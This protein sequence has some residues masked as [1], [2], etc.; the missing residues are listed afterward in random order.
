MYIQL[1][2]I[3]C[4][5]KSAEYETAQALLNEQYLLK[6]ELE[7]QRQALQSKIETLE[8]ELKSFQEQNDVYATLSTNQ[9]ARQ[10]ELIRENVMLQKNVARTCE[11]L[12]MLKES[13]SCMLAEKEEETEGLNTNLQSK[14]ESLKML[15]EK[16]SVLD[17][18]NASV[19]VNVDSFNIELKEKD[20]EIANVTSNLRS[21]EDAVK[22]LL[23][24]VDNLQQN[25]NR[26]L[27][28]ENELN[29]SLFE[30]GEEI[31]VINTNL[32]SKEETVKT[33]LDQ[34][35]NFQTEIT[36]R[37][38]TEELLNTTISEKED[39]L[40]TVK[41]TIDGQDQIIE[42]L[43]EEMNSTELSYQSDLRES[44]E[45]Y[46]DLLTQ[47]NV[48]SEAESTL[49]DLLQSKEDELNAS[50]MHYNDALN[51]K[52]EEIS[53]LKENLQSKEEAVKVLYGKMM[54]SAEEVRFMQE[55]D[56]EYKK[57]AEALHDQKQK[58]ISL[59]TEL[60]SSK[61]SVTA[62]FAA[63][64]E[65]RNDLA[66]ISHKNTLLE[67][68]VIKKDEE[69]GQLQ[70]NLDCLL[71]TH[72]GEVD[73]LKENL[74]ILQRKYDAVSDAESSLQS[75]LNTKEKEFSESI[76]EKDAI[77]SE[78]NEEISNLK[79]HLH[80]KDEAVKVLYEKMQETSEGKE[81]FNV[82]IQQKD[83]EY[84]RLSEILNKQQEKVEL[85]ESELQ[86]SNLQLDV[87]AEIQ[88][89]LDDVVIKKTNLEKSLNQKDEEV[90]LFKENFNNSLIERDQEIMN[91]LE[92]V[93][94]KDEAVKA[95]Y[96]E[97]QILKQKENELDLS[98]TEGDE[99]DVMLTTKD[100]QISSLLED[101]ARLKEE[102]RNI[103]D[104]KTSLSEMLTGKEKELTVC[105]DEFNAIL[106]EKE[107]E[108]SEVTSNLNSKEDTIN[109]M[110]EQ[111][112]TEGEKLEES[113]LLKE[114]IQ[115]QLLIQNSELE[116]LKNT[117]ES[118]QQEN[119][120]LKVK[121]NASQISLATAESQLNEVVSS[122]QEQLDAKTR[123]HIEFKAKATKK[124]RDLN[125]EAKLARSELTK[126]KE[127][128]VL[129]QNKIAELN[130]LYDANLKEVEVMQT[131]STD[132]M[133][134]QESIKQQNDSFTS[135]IDELNTALS[136]SESVQSGLR[137]KL[138]DWST[139]MTNLQE[140]LAERETYINDLHQESEKLTVKMKDKT[141][142]M[143]AVKNMLQD[144][145]GTMQ[146]LQERTLSAEKSLEV[147]QNEL[148]DKT[149]KVA[150]LDDWLKQKDDEYND[151]IAGKQS[152]INKMMEEAT[153]L[154]DLLLE[155]AAQKDE[156]MAE[157]EEKKLEISSLRTLSDNNETIM[158]QLNAYQEKESE[159]SDKIAKLNAQLSECSAQS[160][161]KEEF[162][163]RM[164]SKSEELRQVI[165][166]LGRKDEKL[167]E[168]QESHDELVGL[169]DVLKHKIVSNDNEIN[170]LQNERSK[171]SE[172][173]ENMKVKVARILK[174]SQAMKKVITEK[175]NENEILKNTS[176]KL[177]SKA[178][179]ANANFENIKLELERVNIDNEAIH[180]NCS[181][182]EDRIIELENSC[183]DKDTHID[184]LQSSMY[185]AS[186]LPLIKPVEESLIMAAD[187]SMAASAPS[188]TSA[189]SV[190]QELEWDP[191]VPTK[192][193]HERHCSVDIPLVSPEPLNEQLVNESLFVSS[194]E[195][196][197]F[198]PTSDIGEFV[199][200]GIIENTQQ[201]LEYTTPEDDMKDQKLAILEKDEEIKNLNGKIAQQK[202]VL[203]K[204]KRKIALMKKAEIE[205]AKEF[206][207]LQDVAVKESDMEEQIY[208]LQDQLKLSGG[209]KRGL[210]A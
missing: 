104:D 210:A 126:S 12:D 197:V 137:E 130:H 124:L 27:Q 127:N 46:N 202:E 85:L 103:F 34:L 93:K 7:K 208:S 182:L 142:E 61:D 123:E 121:L 188:E 68:L 177:E 56:E 135:Q 17:Q 153:K 129:L 82:L 67:E 48:A 144:S 139:Q 83:A 136:N 187:T 164:N 143:D 149:Q 60:Q 72:I 11:E 54:N 150:F 146:E 118:T 152:R 99:K 33:L 42:R 91:L 131:S 148:H 81:T 198:A 37:N 209:E 186:Q 6:D 173:H 9:S 95:L 120:E 157:L 206:K 59:E 16:L 204:A 25:N 116:N 78:N 112:K 174:K 154:E 23:E 98:R 70:E 156:A 175:Q 205:L 108:I 96:D 171:L 110:Q 160:N 106:F 49:K 109:L 161:L 43:K 190:L 66:E 180:A 194:D 21:K 179:D 28:Q 117:F 114:D 181:H 18:E 47:F 13:F 55:K 5:E 111:L 132:M 35:E 178:A 193:N 113:E 101:V 29:T 159:Y 44:E 189:T 138:N 64:E 200:E 147:V 2:L 75:L 100:A 26:L 40:Q 4:L 65:L 169:C 77:I 125:K 45:I 24:Q 105:R 71:S 51:E 166:V 63:V 119:D 3:V 128:E 184:N 84:N 10:E 97:N 36:N 30:Q 94:S 201:S 22:M 168:L 199:Q 203:N 79:E 163:K 158:Q 102:S 162:E 87:N 38:K 92:T 80:S 1:F 88:Q 141:E 196:P 172:D 134:E 122:L 185:Q 53:N 69:L 19:K 192:Y 14:E 207:V 15:M 39:D 52:D 74:D 140:V 62:S 183:R 58:S 32:R 31:G 176:I 170:T 57:L 145:M 167:M 50:L 155:T 151:T 41:K 73:S 107:K 20:D 165:E 89:Q 133:N 115:N 191:T 76:T 8:E 86:S 90:S 195:T